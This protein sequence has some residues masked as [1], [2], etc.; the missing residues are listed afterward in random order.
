MILH[1]GLKGTCTQTIG[2]AQTAASIGSGSLPVCATPVICA[3]MEHA[4]VNAIQ[5]CLPSET[6][7]VGVSLSVVHKAPTLTG[8]SVTARAELTR[9]EGRKLTFHI[10]ASDEGGLVAEADHMRVLV[11]SSPFLQKAASRYRS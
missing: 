8:R 2:D 7:S 3:L 4:A 11:E 5:H 9:T 1:I 10:Q 6:T